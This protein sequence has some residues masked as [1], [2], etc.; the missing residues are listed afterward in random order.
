MVDKN[1]QNSLIQGDFL[2]LTGI[3]LP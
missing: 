3:T 2:F 1:N